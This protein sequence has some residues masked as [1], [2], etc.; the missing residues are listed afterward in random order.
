LCDFNVFKST[1]R[2]LG[3]WQGTVKIASDF[4]SWSPELDEAFGI[5]STE[6]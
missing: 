2:Q 3:G 6:K 1:K 5:S 4:D